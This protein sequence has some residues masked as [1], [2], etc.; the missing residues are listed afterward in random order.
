MPTTKPKT[1]SNHSLCALLAGLVTLLL[2]PACARA[3]AWSSCAQYASVTIGSYVV[4]T[5]Y[6][7]QGS[8]PGSQC[9]TA[10]T[11]T[12]AWGVTQFTGTC[13]PDVASYPAI[14]AGCHF[15]QCSPGTNMPI[16]VSNVNC[17]TS[18]WNFSASNSGSYDIAYDIWFGTST[19]TSSHSAELMIWL[20]YL[21]NAPPAG[22][23]QASN[24]SIGGYTFDIYEGN[25]GWNY[26]AYLITGNVTS[27]TNLDIKAF[28][29]DSVSRGYINTGWYLHAIEAGNE[30]RTG[31]APFV[32]NSFS[33]SV[34]GGCS[35]GT[36]TFTFTPTRTFT[37]TN[38]RTSTPTLTRTS[39]ATST[40]TVT[41]TNTPLNTATGTATP[42][43]TNT[44]T[45]TRTATPANT[46]TGTPT[47]SSTATRTNTPANTPTPTATRTSTATSTNTPTT[48]P[49]NTRTATP[50]NTA[51]A[52]AT[53]TPTRTNTLTATNSPTGTATN[54]LTATPSSTPT[55]SATRTSTNTS[56]MT[57][58]TT[59][60]N[61]FTLTAT[62]S[63]TNSATRTNTAVNTPTNTAQNTPTLTGT[64]TATP[65]ATSTSTSSSTNTATWSH[66]S[67]A[68][69][70]PTLTPTFTAT[71][72]ATVTGTTTPTNT[73]TLT[74][75]HTPTATSTYTATSTPTLTFTHSNTVTFTP[76]F[77]STA[78][79][80]TIP[81]NAAS[82]PNST[83]LPGASNV[84][85]LQFTMTNPSPSTVTINGVTVTVSGTGNPDG[86]VTL[87]LLRNGTPAG[88]VVVS[89]NN[90]V[91]NLTD[92]LP[93]S[94]SVTY[95]LAADF[96]G[97]A[98]NGAYIFSLTSAA[99]NNG[100]AVNFSG[101]PANGAMVTVVTSTPTDTPTATWTPK[102]TATPQVP[103][104]KTP[105]VY[106]NPDSGD[107]VYILL[108]P[109]SGNEAVRVQLFTA[110]FRK[111]RDTSYGMIP[112]GVVTVNLTDQWGS[113]LASGVYYVVVS[114][115]KSR[116]I[117][118][119]LVLR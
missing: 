66:T 40:A 88:T 76:S 116:T 4:I 98:G 50:T 26:I 95:Q 55:G 100:Q 64:N 102:Q 47:N 30:F 8:C 11:S 15:G 94:S 24:V 65:T 60:T 81:V 21:G 72:T 58:T 44:P 14:Y 85:V 43:R 70:T 51:A 119:L 71:W 49:T 108:P 2:S 62:P 59:P 111:I 118:K 57:G 69:P 46:A 104:V 23:L 107:K 106:P 37:P 75:T 105:V 18:S 112:S 32:T 109:Y 78:T 10:N 117:Q 63:P 31:G 91:F 80:V 19:N 113:S 96:S 25:I 53:S 17:A 48:T 115:G 90:A 77:T 83:Q 92:S 93:A 35:G 101:L 54:T 79:V 68:T 13:A 45:N 5:N 36:P 27:V 22:T 1:F 38:T 41:R 103:P 56:T 84:P 7:S 114:V 20:N 97:S 86:A 3:Q 39:S 33:A 42:T 12:G 16:L 52:T 67:T 34:N 74:D 6:W 110:A 29:N 28:I 61:S 73:Y 87:T 9:V 99:G 82:V 89:G